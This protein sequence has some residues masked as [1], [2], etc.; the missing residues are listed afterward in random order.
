MWKMEE[1][2]IL[3]FEMAPQ[4]YGFSTNKKKKETDTIHINKKPP[5]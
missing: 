2:D 4:I 5:N 3:W 1:K